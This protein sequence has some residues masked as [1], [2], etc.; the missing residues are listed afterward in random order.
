[1]EKVADHL[2]RLPVP[3]RE[4]LAWFASNAGTDQPWPQPIASGQEQILLASKAKGIYKPSWS[5]YALSVRQSLG[6]PYPDREPVVR[7][8]GT[9]LYSYFQENEDPSARDEEY[10]NRGMVACWRDRVPVGVMRQVRGKPNV[11]YKILG[12][13]LVG[14][15]DGGY[16]FLEGFAPDGRVRDRGPAGEIELLAAKAEPIQFD[17][18]NIIDG[19]ERIVAQIV[20]RRGQPEF[21]RRLLEAYRGRCAISGCD[22]VEALE[23][24][25]IAPYRGPDTNRLDNGLLLRADLHTLFDLGLISIA[26]TPMTLVIAT[27][28][29]ETIYREFDGKQLLLPSDEAARPSIEAL[30][31][32]RAWSGL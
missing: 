3:H 15:W 5:Q 24:A 14:G 4:A 7:P 2:A 20:L 26:S 21:R 17:P 6:A 10:T 13:A 23:A 1:M 25:H 30:D 28:L 9:W 16:F 19:R 31:F 32:H 18:A 27:S 22:A 29:A 11:R 12:L 8:D